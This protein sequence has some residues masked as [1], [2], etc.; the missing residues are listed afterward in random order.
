MWKYECDAGKYTED[1]LVK[2]L[3]VIFSHRFSHL[4][5]GEGFSDQ[6]PYDGG[7]IG[8]TGIDQECGEQVRKP[9]QA[10]QTRKCKR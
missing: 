9:P 5:K 2:L 3:Y 7:E 4:L 8:S 6:C 10:Q 1:S